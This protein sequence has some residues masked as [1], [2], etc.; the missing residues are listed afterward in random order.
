MSA[1]SVAC[2]RCESPFEGGDVR[3][4]VCGHAA[5]DVIREDV[6]KAAVEVLRCSGCGA[7][8]SYSV[9]ARA[10]QCAFCGSIVQLE[11][12]GDPMEQAESVVP[13]TVD[14]A[15]AEEVFRDWLGSLGWFRPADLRSASRLE[16]MR[17]LWWVG[18]V[19]SADALVSWTADS[20]VGAARADWAPHA[21]QTELQ[22]E[23]IVV[24][25][26]R[27]LTGEETACLLDSYDLST[28]RSMTTAGDA[29]AVTEQFEVR[30][31]VARRQVRSELR[32]LTAERLRNG[33]I[34]GRR[35]RNLHTSLLVSKLRTRRMGFP[36]W[37]IAYRYR[38]A[39]HRFVLSGQ[40]PACRLGDAPTS[41]ARIA[42]AI[43]AAVG[44][45]AVLIA[46][47]AL[48]AS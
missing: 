3:C 47:L 22:F 2:R 40:D 42:I 37:V 38:G 11:L 7:A 28:A 10:P 19:V 1:G 31:T 4:A 20:E 21:G 18:W 27:G 6:P 35:I 15:R 14:R 41:I 26:S 33:V 45:L 25:A 43:A 39:L 23:D 32:R 12:P 48:L 30:R 36:A 5:P 29:D 46:M 8:V 34:P 9:R 13:F 44:G 16:S 24:S 17:A